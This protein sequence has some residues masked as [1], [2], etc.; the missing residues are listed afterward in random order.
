MSKGSLVLGLMQPYLFPYIG[1]FQL[2]YSCDK[3]IIYDDVQYIKSGWVNRNRIIQQNE[4]KYFTLPVKRA[5]VNTQINNYFYADVFSKNKSKILRQIESS[6]KKSPF[7]NDV[8][9]LIQECFDSSNNNISEF[10]VLTIKLCCNYL[11]IDTPI[12]LS[13]ELTLNEGITGQERVIYINKIMNSTHY[14]NP[15]GGKDLYSHDEFKKHD[16][17]LNFLKTNNIKYPQFNNEHQSFLSIIDVMMFN[18][19]EQIQLLL[20]KYDLVD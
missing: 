19:Q 3:F 6:Y 7:F 14:I 11:S 12:F 10:N 5:P 16:I 15:I 8:F 20:S 4:I 17:K 18:S 1:Y 9:K 2:I 13:S